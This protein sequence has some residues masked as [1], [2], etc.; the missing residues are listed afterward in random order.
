MTRPPTI[1]TEQ[2]GRHVDERDARPKQ[3]PQQDERDLVDHRAADEEG[4]HH[5]E[6]DAGLDE[7]DEEGHGG[8]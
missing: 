3:T 2:P 5:P 6:R 8:A 7:A 4:E 1:A